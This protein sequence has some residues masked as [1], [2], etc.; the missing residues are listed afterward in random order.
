MVGKVVKIQ[1]VKHE[2]GERRGENLALESFAESEPPQQT[3]PRALGGLCQGQK[4]QAPVK[5]RR[6]GQIRHA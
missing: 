5:E 3:Q 1:R 2:A 4:Q 6:R